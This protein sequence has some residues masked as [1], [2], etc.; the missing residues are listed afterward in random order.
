MRELEHDAERRMEEFCRSFLSNLLNAIDRCERVLTMSNRLRYHA[1]LL[2]GKDA[3]S[4][5]TVL[6][7][8]EGQVFP[9]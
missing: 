1:M 3:F 8:E 6:E 4:A 5:F 9:E 2:G 7:I